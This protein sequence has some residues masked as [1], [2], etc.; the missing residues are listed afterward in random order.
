MDGNNSPSFYQ[1]TCTQTKNDR[2]PWLTVDLL[3]QYLIHKV[4]ITNRD[5]D[6]MSMIFVTTETEQVA[7]QR[8]GTS[9]V[10]VKVLSGKF[11]LFGIFLANDFNTLFQKYL[12]WRE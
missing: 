3:Q 12:F 4:K 1:D 8:L 10:K 7:Y 5:Q 2:I 6:G 9:I 11:V